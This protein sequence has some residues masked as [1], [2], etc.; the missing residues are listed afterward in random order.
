MTSV[1]SFTFMREFLPSM[2]NQEVSLFIVQ[3]LIS[4]CIVSNS[5]WR[6]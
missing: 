2:L 5:L 3:G 4:A 6:I 1:A